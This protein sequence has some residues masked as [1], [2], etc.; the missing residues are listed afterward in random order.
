M[1]TP[2]LNIMPS[3]AELADKLR[4][5][6]ARLQVEARVPEFQDLPLGASSPPADN[7]SLNHLFDVSCT[8]AAELGRIKMPLGEVLKFSAGTVVELDRL[9]SQPVDVLV[10]DVLLARGEVVVV[11]DRFAIR[12]LEIVN[13]KKEK[14]I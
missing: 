1:P 6:S 9:V 2:T 8:V 7:Q 12:I 10:Q 11:N 13:P 14:H 5:E 4:E 3:G